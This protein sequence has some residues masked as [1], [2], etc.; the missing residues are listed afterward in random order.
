[1]LHSELDDMPGIGEK[2]R[3]LL[4]ERFGSVSGVKQASE[5]DLL[6]ARGRLEDRA[7]AVRGRQ[8][9][10]RS[11][12]LEEFARRGADV[13]AL[14]A[15]GVALAADDRIRDL[16]AQSPSVIQ[17]GA[18]EDAFVSRRESLRDRRRRA[19]HVDDDPD[20]GRRLLVRRE[21]N[22]N[23]HVSTLLRA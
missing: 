4:I 19:H 22:V 20:I 9:Q 14:D 21:G 23:A 16:R 2:R 11:A 7:R 13:E 5:Q 10:R 15:H 1:M 18:A 12:A 17:L 3:R 6:A 8:D